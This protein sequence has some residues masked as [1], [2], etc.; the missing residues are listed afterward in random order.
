MADATNCL[1]DAAKS[2]VDR[3]MTR[4]QDTLTQEQVAGLK[5]LA[6]NGQLFDVEA[7][8]TLADLSN[9]P[10]EATHGN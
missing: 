9:Q 5:Q 10:S 6:S 4:L 2:V 8:V 1:S 3:T 7:L